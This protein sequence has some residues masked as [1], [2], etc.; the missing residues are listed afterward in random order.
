MT[1]VPN[2]PTIFAPRIAV[3]S[4][5]SGNNREDGALRT[6]GVSLPT[7]PS[8]IRSFLSLA[9]RAPQNESNPAD[10]LFR[11]ESQTLPQQEKPKCRLWEQRYDPPITPQTQEHPLFFLTGL[12]P[13]SVLRVDSAKLISGYLFLFLLAVQHVAL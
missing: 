10:V 7:P 9:R 4:L 5:L 2:I 12:F 1:P 3:F 13:L 11:L 6:K 8:Y